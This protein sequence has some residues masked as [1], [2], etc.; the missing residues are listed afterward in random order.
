MACEGKEQQSFQ[1]INKLTQSYGITVCHD[2]IV[3]TV[4]YRDFYHP[5]EAYIRNSSLAPSFDKLSGKMS[6]S[7]DTFSFEG[8]ESGEKL[9]IVYPYGCS[10]QI[11]TPAA[12]LQT[13]GAL[14]FP[15]NRAICAY[16]QVKAGRLIVMGSSLCFDDQYIVKGD[17][18]YLANGIMKLLTEPGPKLESV[19]VDRPEYGPRIEIPDTEALAERVRACLQEG[20]ELPLDFTQLFDHTLFKYDTNIIPEAVALYEKLNVKHEPLSL[21]PPQFEVPLPPLQPAVFMPCMRELPP[22][23][24]DLFDLDEHFSS[25]KL[26]LA[27]LTNKCTDDDLEYFVRESGEILGVS[28]L[29]REEM[30]QHKHLTPEEKAVVPVEGKKILEYILTKLVAYKK[31]EQ[32][33][34][35][36]H[37]FKLSFF[38]IHTPLTAHQAD[39]TQH[40]QIYK[41]QGDAHNDSMMGN[42]M[43]PGGQNMISM[44]NHNSISEAE[45]DSLQV[46][47]MYMLQCMDYIP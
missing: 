20:E 18:T 40:V 11:E 3:R 22:P 8:T 19:D 5:K 31:I 38:H 13:S 2:S 12:P 28:D 37:S 4:Y 35:M 33:V 46:R 45:I 7:G 1:H 25:E 34:Y 39:Q 9:N 27:Q 44:E 36:A 41:F 10:L 26:R 42:S 47:K 24:L 6:S 14:T 29:I 32:E 43:G 23:N 15:A 16:T 21:I 30:P 17:N